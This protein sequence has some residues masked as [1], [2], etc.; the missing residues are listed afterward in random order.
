MSSTNQVAASG[1]VHSIDALRGFDM[2][3]IVGG[4]ALFV[5]FLSL[6]DNPVAQFF[7]GQLHHVEWSGFHFYDLIFPLFLFIIGASIPFATGKRLERGDSRRDI[8]LHIV[9]R[10]ATLYI[11]G[12]IYYGLFELKFDQL[13]FG[14]VLQRLALGYFF[15]SIIFMNFKVKWQI[16]ISAAILLIYWAI[17][18]LI[19]APGCEAG[20]FDPSCN[21]GAWFDNNIVPGK[22][23]TYGLFTGDSTSLFSTPTAVV[24]TMIGVLCGQ[25]LKSNETGTRKTLGLVIAG[26]SSIV[27][28]YI[29]GTVFTIN[30][31]LWTSTYV[32]LAGGWSMLLLAAFY[33]II[34]V[35]GYRRWAFPF[36]V[37]GMNAI[38]IYLASRF[39]NFEELA[40][41][42]IQGI[43]R[44]TG[45]FTATFTALSILAVKWLLFYYLYRQ[46]IF[47]KV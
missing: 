11:L 16:G 28:A 38:A 26:I 22:L 25:W 43:V 33:W 35:K 14:G 13:R 46:K 24:S 21:L 8:F 29:W 44:Y 7:N 23:H 4:D 41:I 40:F 10:A 5:S 32:M 9:K 42:F 47:I 45:D 19:P 31:F 1:R 6:F 12:L 17:I 30:K 20:S 39:I 36:T 18:A 15:A 3:W 27:I 34:D 37:I 2:F